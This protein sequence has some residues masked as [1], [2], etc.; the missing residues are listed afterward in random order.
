A[1]TNGNGNEDLLCQLIEGVMA[2]TGRAEDGL[3]EAVNGRSAA[4]D[5]WSLGLT[6]SGLRD[7]PRTELTS[8]HTCNP[9]AA[10]EPLTLPA[11]P[12]SRPRPS[13]L[14]SGRFPQGM[15]WAE[16]EAEASQLGLG[17]DKSPTNPSS[18]DLASPSALAAALAAIREAEAFSG[19]D[20][21][22][23][24]KNAGSDSPARSNSPA[25][26]RGSAIVSGPS[27]FRPVADGGPASASAA[28]A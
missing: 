1:L 24:P 23:T 18:S 6:L 3:S 27:R 28:A 2:A 11:T 5:S 9:T 7:Q 25:L 10:A 4:S 14:A 16:V 15:S 21:D 8:G 26:G 12:S 22:V 13:P 20:A 17:P 19:T